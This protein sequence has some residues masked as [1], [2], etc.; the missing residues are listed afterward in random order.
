YL[1]SGSVQPSAS[2]LSPAWHTAHWSAAF[3]NLP[4]SGRVYGDAA[5]ALRQRSASAILACTKLSVSWDPLS[6]ALPPCRS[7]FLST[8]TSP[9]QSSTQQQAS[10]PTGPCHGS[11]MRFVLC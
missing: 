6:S 11:V 2:A 7:M 4:S 3:C 5:A 1:D 8:R 9:R 10:L